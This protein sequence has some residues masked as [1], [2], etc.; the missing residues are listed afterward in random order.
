MNTVPC[1][2]PGIDCKT[3]AGLGKAEGAG[4]SR[5][6][7]RTCPDCRGGGKRLCDVFGCHRPATIVDEDDAACCSVCER[8][9]A[10]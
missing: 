9:E 4:T 8:L 7:W 2:P 3:C 10:E 6:R 1:A 5:E